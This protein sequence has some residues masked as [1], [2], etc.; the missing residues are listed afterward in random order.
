VQT[1]INDYKYYLQSGINKKWTYNIII[2]LLVEQSQYVVAIINYHEAAEKCP[3]RIFS[4]NYFQFI[5][6]QMLEKFTWFNHQ[7]NTRG[8]Q[9]QTPYKSPL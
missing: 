9:S 5:E 4:I 7:I 1:D 6:N 2:Y 3:R 8:A